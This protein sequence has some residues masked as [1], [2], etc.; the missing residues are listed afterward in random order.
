M[1]P[2][3]SAS[4]RVLRRLVLAVEVLEL[5][6]VPTLT[7]PLNPQLDQFGSQI[8]T[9]MAYGDAS[10]TTFGIF[11]T[12]A[13]PITFSMGAQQGFT[14]QG[15]PIPIKVDDGAQASGIGGSVTGDVSQPGTILADGLHAYQMTI[16]NF[17]PPELTANFNANSARTPG[18][19]AFVGD[20]EGSPGLPTVTGTPILN[21]SS[22]NP[23]GLGALARMQGFQ[24]DLSG[25]FP[26]MGLTAP[27]LQFVSPT[28]QLYATAADLSLFTMP[29]SF[30]GSDNHTNPGNNVTQSYNPE[31]NNVSLSQGSASVGGK[32]MLLDTGS[33]VTIISTALAQ[34]LG[35]D[36]SHPDTNISV[37]G[38][39]GAQTVPGFTLSSLVLPGLGTSSLRF[40]H[41][42]VYVLDAAPGVDGILG[43]NLFNRAD[44]I[45]YNP[46]HHSGAPQFSV[47]FFADPARDSGGSGLTGGVGTLLTGSHTISPPSKPVPPSSSHSRFNPIFVAVTNQIGAAASLPT[48]LNAVAAL[49]QSQHAANAAATESTTLA[50]SVTTTPVTTTAT[51]LATSRTSQTASLASLFSPVTATGLTLSSATPNSPKA[52]TNSSTV[53][54]AAQTPISPTAPTRFTDNQAS[55][56]LLWGGAGD[57][58]LSVVPTKVNP[59]RGPGNKKGPENA[60]PVMPPVID[61]EAPPAVAVP[62]GPDAADAYFADPSD[63]TVRLEATFLDQEQ[64][65]PALAAA[66]LTFVLGSSRDWRPASERAKTRRRRWI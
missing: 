44:G 65:R 42:P 59:Q 55:D 37:Q 66:A 9:V 51:L 52:A 64:L 30:Y 17:G 36:L 24:L 1:N 53:F 62:L 2:R 10:R 3:S 54:A 12:G 45:F 57:T 61:G 16:N 23:R 14:D 15:V 58:G 11:D 6:L 22:N 50:P 25:L 60:P 63:E 48:L 35:L 8:Q 20:L 21:R 33:Q 38:V 41:V 29:L 31:A 27:D 56:G 7:I 28:T 5:R 19:Q 49:R 13:S 43:M 18:I 47:T 34:S 40:T 39:G 26:G 4:A 32:N 46:F